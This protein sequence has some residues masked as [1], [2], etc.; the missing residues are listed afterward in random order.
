[1]PQNSQMQQQSPRQMNLPGME[2]GTQVGLSGAGQMMGM[3]SS[4]KA[5]MR[6][7]HDTVKAAMDSGE[8]DAEALAAEAP[9]ALKD[10]A[11]AQ[12]TDV[13]SMLEG[14][15]ERMEEM[16]S[17]GPPP[18]GMGGPQGGM[19]MG[20]MSEMGVMGGMPPMGPPPGGGM[21]GPSAEMESFMDT[22]VEASDSEE[23]DI[24]A[25]IEA[26]PEEVEAMAAELGMD[27]EALVSDMLSR[28]EEN[29]D[30]REQSPRDQM[31]N[32]Q[33]MEAYSAQIGA[34]NMRGFMDALF[35]S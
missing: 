7:F 11:E 23:V 26:A 20:G 33:G 15:P 19:Q 29:G 18:G 34:D 35:A 28:V 2:S 5:E 16:A 24:E 6:D 3:D 27:V 17:M 32:Q 31:R 9:Q 22:L 8:F 14:L 4:S 13:A 1:M 12:G 21:G 10:A 30:P 25:L